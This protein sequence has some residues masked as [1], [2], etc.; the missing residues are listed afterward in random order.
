MLDF[1]GKAP[2][3]TKVR[4]NFRIKREL[5]QYDL[6][7][8]PQAQTITH[9]P[10][11]AAE[12]KLKSNNESCIIYPLFLAYPPIIPTYIINSAFWAMHSWMVNSTALQDGWDV[13][14]LV[15]R[16]LWQ[17][18]LCRMMFERAKL[19]NRVLLFDSP[20]GLA[21]TH[22][23]GKKF[24]ATTLPYFQ[25]YNRCLLADTDLFAS[26]IEDAK[27]IDMA[28]FKNMGK[29]QGEMLTNSW[30][31]RTLAKE[32]RYATQKYL[33]ITDKEAHQR[34]QC[35]I[36][37]YLGYGCDKYYSV[38]DMLYTFCPQR[39]N[40]DFKDNVRLLTKDICDDEDQYGL[41]LM[42]TGRKPDK[43]HKLRQGKVPLCFR[44]EDY[45]AGYDQYLDHI[46]LDRDPDKGS[47]EKK[48]W[49]KDV[50]KRQVQ[51]ISAYDDPEIAD[52]WRN[53]IG[54]HRRVQ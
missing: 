30:H 53:N 1:D 43:L 32:W 29:D 47:E 45:F 4:Y 8:L 24:Y 17:D 12:L 39:L 6:D 15:E 42:K 31:R 37:N 21:Q 49:Y 2:K 36:R 46:W 54:L 18:K 19:R 9:K 16:E 3:L 11:E 51:P 52:I 50:E 28:L 40:D 23:L 44:R 26:R 22:Q 27:L 48:A 13:W 7:P 5:P 14:F 25:N 33:D 10:Q 41:Y 35:L 34:Y 38:T 20:K